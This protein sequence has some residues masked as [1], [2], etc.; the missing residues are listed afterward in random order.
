MQ[1]GDRRRGRRRRGRTIFGLDHLQRTYKYNGRNFRLTDVAG[2]V[3]KD[4]IA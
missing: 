1:A 3:V 2:V 4:V